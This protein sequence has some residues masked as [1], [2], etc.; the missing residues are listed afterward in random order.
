MSAQRFTTLS[1]A[2]QAVSDRGS[3][4]G[5]VE[6]NFNRIAGLW[7]VLLGKE[8]TSAQVALC[9]A[10]LKMARLVETPNHYDSWVDL[11]GYAACGSQ[12]ECKKN[13]GVGGI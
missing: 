6:D 3:S 5:T 2:A 12:V 1:D 4:Y 7:S 9:L 10:A 11:A 13:R 8:V